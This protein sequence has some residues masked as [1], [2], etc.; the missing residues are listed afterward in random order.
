MRGCWAPRAGPLSSSAHAQSLFSFRREMVVLHV[1]VSV[2]N[3]TGQR[4]QR[5]PRPLRPCQQ[6]AVQ[7][8]SMS[9]VQPSNFRPRT[10]SAILPQSKRQS[11]TLLHSAMQ[12]TAAGWASMPHAALHHH[13]CHGLQPKWV[14]VSGI[15]GRGGENGC[16]V[17]AQVTCPII[18]TRNR[19]CRTGQCAIFGCV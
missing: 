18:D 13:H 3:P 4:V 9:T 16:A 12:K 1:S 7:P 11:L 14:R 15:L 10:S 8:M 17:V 6:T 2:S 19:A 5:V